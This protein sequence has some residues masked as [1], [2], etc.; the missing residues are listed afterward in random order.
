MDPSPK[1]QG[2][3]KAVDVRVFHTLQQAITATYV[4]SYRLVKNGETFG[5]IT[6]R[7]A[8]NFDEFEKIIEEFKNA[9]IFYNYVLVYQN[10]Q[11]EFTREQEKVKKHL[12][13]RR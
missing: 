12:G 7:I 13:Y 3:Q 9:D 6:H 1:A 8:A 2:V 10:G 11:M 5:F 4:Q